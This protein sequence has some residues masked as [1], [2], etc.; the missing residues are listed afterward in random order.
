MFYRA[1]KIYYLYTE[2]IKSVDTKQYSLNTIDTNDLFLAESDECAF[3]KYVCTF[4]G[5]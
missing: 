4:L 3:G 1:G 2:I 5:H